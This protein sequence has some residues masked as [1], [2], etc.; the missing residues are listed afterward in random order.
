[1][2]LIMFYDIAQIVY[3]PNLMNVIV[4]LLIEVVLENPNLIDDDDVKPKKEIV[5][6]SKELSLYLHTRRTRLR[7][8]ISELR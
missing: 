1:V 7:F 5:S 3:Y 2:N 4:D 6:I 8:V